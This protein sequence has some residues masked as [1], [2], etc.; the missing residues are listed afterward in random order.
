[1]HSMLCRSV[2]TVNTKHIFISAHNFLNI[3]LIF[4]LEKF[5]KA[6]TQSFPTIPL[7]TMYV[8]MVDTSCKYF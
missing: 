1:M 5:W 4:N 8:N 2:D 6:E 7:N 3:Q